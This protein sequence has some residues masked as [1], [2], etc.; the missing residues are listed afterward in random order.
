[1]GRRNSF[2]TA[3]WFASTLF[4]NNLQCKLLVAQAR[5]SEIERSDEQ[6]L[7]EPLKSARDL[8][9]LPG[10]ARTRRDA[11]QRDPMSCRENPAVRWGAP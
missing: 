3:S 1:M 9:S 6:A 5:L 4:A 7:L 11:K 8:N 2:G 10:I